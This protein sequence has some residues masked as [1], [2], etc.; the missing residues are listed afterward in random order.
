MARDAQTRKSQISTVFVLAL[1]TSLFAFAI[2]LKVAPNLSDFR[3]GSKSSL[4]KIWVEPDQ[5]LKAKLKIAPIIV[6]VILFFSGFA[7]LQE[8][9][10][11]TPSFSTCEAAP[12][13]IFIESRHWFRPPPLF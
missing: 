2:Y 5:P 4:V 8:R 13:N 6:P 7:L 9:H 12:L 10:R 11:P 1:V 3:G